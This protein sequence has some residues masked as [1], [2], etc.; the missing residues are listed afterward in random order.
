M[1]TMLAFINRAFIILGGSGQFVGAKR[2]KKN[3]RGESFYGS[4]PCSAPTNC[5]CRVSEDVA[6][7]E[8]LIHIESYRDQSNKARER[9]NNAN[10]S[11][12]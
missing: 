6:D 1:T 4:I 9:I 3:R 5:P 2:A 10:L 8:T 7:K 12:Q 11:D